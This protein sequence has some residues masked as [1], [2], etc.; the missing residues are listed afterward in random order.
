MLERAAV[1]YGFGNMH[2]ADFGIA[3][4][5]GNGPGDFQHAMVSPRRPSQARHCMTKQQFAIG[6]GMA[7]RFQPGARQCGIESALAQ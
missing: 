4:Q 2:V 3:S 5:I 1:L 6:A 7:G